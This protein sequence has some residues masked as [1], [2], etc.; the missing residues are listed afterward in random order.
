YS[1]EEI[2]AQL[3]I[4]IGTVKTK[5]HRVRERLSKQMKENE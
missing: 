2:A 5:I 4:P 1:Y 3:D